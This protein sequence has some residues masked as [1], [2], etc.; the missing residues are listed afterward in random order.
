MPSICGRPDFSRSIIPDIRGWEELVSRNFANSILLCVEDE[1]VVIAKVDVDPARVL[2]AC[3]IGRCLLLE[4]AI[5]SIG[6]W[7]YFTY[8]GRAVPSTSLNQAPLPPL[9]TPALA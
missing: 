4:Q 5:D 3:Y 2:V 8:A 1:G 9:N 6:F 7:R